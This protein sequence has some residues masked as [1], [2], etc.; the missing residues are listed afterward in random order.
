[1]AREKI[2]T[3]KEDFQQ[4]ETFRTSDIQDHLLN[5]QIELL[6]LSYQSRQID[7]KKLEEMVSLGNAIENKFATFRAEI[8]G[9]QYTDNQIEEILYT[10]TD[11]EAVKKAWLASKHIGNVVAHDV[12]QIVKMRNAVATSL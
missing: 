4:I 3:N 2:Y 8:D 1:M 11:S 7:E 10:S 9:N 6:F 12:I 5:R